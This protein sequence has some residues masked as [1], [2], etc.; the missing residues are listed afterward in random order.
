MRTRSRKRFA[1]KSDITDAGGH[2]AAQNK[3]PSIQ[4]DCAEIDHM[5]FDESTSTYHVF[6][7]WPNGDVSEHPREEI[8]EKCPQQCIL[9]LDWASLDDKVVGKP[10]GKM[11]RAAAV[12]TIFGPAKLSVGSLFAFSRRQEHHGP[13]STLP[14]VNLSILKK[15]KDIF[16]CKDS[17]V[18]KGYRVALIIQYLVSPPEPRMRQE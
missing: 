3:G 9:T 7:K 1:T 6:L 18:F 17:P 8:Y 13:L 11:L 5:E 15:L 12:V 4:W 14:I 10:R 16:R 2:S